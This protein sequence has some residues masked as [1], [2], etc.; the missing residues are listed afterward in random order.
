[1]CHQIIPRTLVIRIAGFKWTLVTYDFLKFIE[2]FTRI[3]I[4]LYLFL[5]V[6]YDSRVIDDFVRLIV[7]FVRNQEFDEGCLS[8]SITLDELLDDLGTIT[9]PVFINILEVGSANELIWV[10]SL[11]GHRNYLPIRKSTVWRFNDFDGGGLPYGG[12]GTT[13]EFYCITSRANSRTVEDFIGIASK[14]LIR[15]DGPNSFGKTNKS[16]MFFCVF[17]T[18]MWDWC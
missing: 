9:L 8:V 7:T 3:V 14:D 1:M 5:D 11:S 13:I 2:L 10:E 4:N 15:E 17:L 6:V 18:E 12:H 16:S